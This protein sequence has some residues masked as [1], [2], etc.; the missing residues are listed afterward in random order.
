MV[1]SIE[2]G[3]DTLIAKFKAFVV[4]SVFHFSLN[5]ESQKRVL[6]NL[7]TQSS[8]PPHYYHSYVIFITVVLLYQSCHHRYTY[9]L[10][11]GCGQQQRA[12]RLLFHPSP[13]WSGQKNG[14]KKAKACV[15]G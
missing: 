8:N 10:Q 1:F 15:S 4:L 6:F 14:K 11:F 7:L 2:S 12:M 9:L 5:I 3:T 13:R